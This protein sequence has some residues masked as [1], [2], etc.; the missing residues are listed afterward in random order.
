MI[1]R[2]Y[3]K[4]SASQ[5]KFGLP[6]IPHIQ[7]KVKNTKITHAPHLL[8]LHLLPVLLDNCCYFY[9]TMR[10]MPLLFSMAPPLL[11]PITSCRTSFTGEIL[12]R[13][14]FSSLISWMSTVRLTSGVENCLMKLS[15]TWERLKSL[16]I[17]Y[18]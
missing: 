4:F 5:I 17:L 7:G 13:V 16:G 15:L 11:D 1:L 9:L 2:K 10:V 18:R 14:V 3:A 12:T 8:H 6:K